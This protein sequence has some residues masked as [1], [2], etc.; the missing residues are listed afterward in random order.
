MYVRK[1]V[2]AKLWDY[3]V[4]P[5]PEEVVADPYENGQVELSADLVF[6]SEG[7]EPGGFNAPRDVAV[8]PDGSIYVAD[9]RN[10]R[11]QRFAPE[12]ELLNA[13][14][15][16]ADVAAGAAPEGTFNEPWGVAV[17]PDGSVYVADTWN[18]R[19]Q[20]FDSGGTFQAM[21]GYFGQGE[22]PFAFWGPRA[23]AVDD[24]GR[25]YVS[26]TGNKRVVV[27]DSQGG[28]LT[29]FGGVGVEPG[30]FDEPVGL[31]VDG[32]HNVYIADTWNQRVQVFREENGSFV[33]ETTWEIAGWYGQSLDNKP[34]LAVDGQGRVF[35]TDPEGA[36]VIEFTD[37][38]D[39]I[40]YWGSFGV[41]PEGFG[42]ASGIAVDMSGSV[43][44]SDG[45]N[46]RLM[47]F[48][49]PTES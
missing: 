6:G 47:R 33:P 4:G 46:N 35:V 32:E 21:W 36:R 27:F 43:W 5:A 42:L 3:G 45:G 31:T 19:V 8:G 34:Y 48:A 28:A 11:I 30:Y 40:R 20:K 49:L 38:G 16:F 18:H 26:D 14:G 1:D 13:W 37:G 15:T 39:F 29:E 10:H 41:G 25:V 44:V 9:S 23:V 12:G 24:Q 2:A 17:G 7:T 22:D